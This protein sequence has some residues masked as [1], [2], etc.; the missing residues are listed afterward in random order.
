MRFGQKL[1]IDIADMNHNNFGT[2]RH[3]E[4]ALNFVCIVTMIDNVLFP[5]VKFVIKNHCQALFGKQ[6]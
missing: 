5:F 3:M 1:S 6:Q 2:D 4:T